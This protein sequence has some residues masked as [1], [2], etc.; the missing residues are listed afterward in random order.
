MKKF[1][2]SAVLALLCAGSSFAADIPVL[3]CSYGITTQ[4]G[5]AHV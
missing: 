5:R 3:R 1:I 2:L 4:I